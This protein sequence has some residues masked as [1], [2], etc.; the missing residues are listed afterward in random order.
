MI[1]QM[2]R[3]DVILTLENSLNARVLEEFAR[4]TTARPRRS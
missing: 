3:C 2:Q 4:P 1:K